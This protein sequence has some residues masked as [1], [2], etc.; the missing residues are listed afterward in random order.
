[1]SSTAKQQLHQLITEYGAALSEDPKRVKALLLDVCQQHRREANMLTT[2]AQQGLA[3]QLYRDDG[4]T[5]ASL[6][7]PRLVKQLHRDLGV[8][9]ALATWAVDAWRACLLGVETHITTNAQPRNTV[10]TMS[11]VKPVSATPPR[12]TNVGNQV[13]RPLS[14]G[15]PK[16]RII[17]YALC[18]TAVLLMGFSF[19]E[20][21][22]GYKQRPH[23]ERLH[24]A[25]LQGDPAAQFD[26]GLVAPDSEQAVVW[27]RKAADKGLAPAQYQL[28]LSYMNG[29][30]VEQSDE[31]AAA[32]YRQAAEQDHAPSQYQLALMYLEGRG[33]EQNDEQAVN[34]YR[35]AATNGHLQAQV[36]MGWLH[37]KD[38][39]TAGLT[40][41]LSVHAVVWRLRAEILSHI[42][43]IGK[44]DE[45]AVHYYRRAA[46]QGNADGH[47]MLGWML[48]HGT[49]IDQNIELAVESYRKAAEQG[50][51]TA[52]QRLGHLLQRE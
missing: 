51:I 8:D 28:A 32:W 47:Y 7:V 44:S 48:E 30:G 4:K 22:T 16:E 40:E 18:L 33:V 41:I 11:I 35:S 24:H 3:S 6:I 29:I 52:Q 37:H 45:Q 14:G 39:L 43:F 20:N 36:F 31:Q 26:L 17:T 5:P 42:A 2:V 50:N 12:A 21:G 1:M 27:Y 13:S 25:A 10:S 38:Y 34:W 9:V 23:L 46:E 19:F 49:G 15:E